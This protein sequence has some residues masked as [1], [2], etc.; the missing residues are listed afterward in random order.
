MFKIVKNGTQFIVQVLK[1]GAVIGKRLFGRGALALLAEAGLLADTAKVRIRKAIVK[2]AQDIGVKASD[3]HTVL[4]K[5]GKVSNGEPIAAAGNVME[6]VGTAIVRSGADDMQVK[7]LVLRSLD[8][9][10]KSSNFWKQGTEEF[11]A[12]MLLIAEWMKNMKDPM[13]WKKL[14]AGLAAIGGAAAVTYWL[15]DDENGDDMSNV[16]IDQSSTTNSGTQGTGLDYTGGTGSFDI[17]GLDLASGGLT[18]GGLD[19]VAGAPLTCDSG[20]IQAL[21]ALS[22]ASRESGVRPEGIIRIIALVNPAVATA[23]HRAWA[24]KQAH[25]GLFH[26]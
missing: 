26:A 13:S 18:E 9:V 12:R 20:T 22:D 3:L 7:A 11:K 17:P 15:L 8:E 25:P 19:P 6:E 23:L 1:G 21:V 16:F 2:L 24:Y 4:K 14:G 5:G 10:D